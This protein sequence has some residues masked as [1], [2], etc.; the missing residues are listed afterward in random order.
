MPCPFRTLLGHPFNQAHILAQRIT[1]AAPKLEITVG[2]AGVILVENVSTA[3][4]E[5]NSENSFNAVLVDNTSTTSGFGAG[6]VTALK[7][8]TT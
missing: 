6:L 2:A 1:P 7:K 3:L 8:K 4:K 5:S